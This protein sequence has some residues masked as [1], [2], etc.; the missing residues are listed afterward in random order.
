MWVRAVTASNYGAWSEIYNQSGVEVG[1]TLASLG[2]ASGV[3][4]KRAFITNS[5]VAASGN[6]GATAAGGGANR[7]PVWSDGTNWRIG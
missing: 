2:A 3:P 5:N 6:F 7:V 1:V 4:Y